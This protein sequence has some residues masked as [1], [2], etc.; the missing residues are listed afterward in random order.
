MMDYTK[1]GTTEARSSTKQ[2]AGMRSLVRRIARLA[3]VWLWTKAMRRYLKGRDFN[4]E[5]VAG[6]RGISLR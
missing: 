5:N 4:S 1:Q 3:K 2:T 6:A